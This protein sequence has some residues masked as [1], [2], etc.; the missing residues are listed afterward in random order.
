MRIKIS[1]KHLEHTEAIDKAIHEKTKKLDKYFHGVTQVIWTC[2]V[3]NGKHLAEVKILGPSFD[4]LARSK[5]DNLYKSLDLVLE[6]LEKQLEKKKDKWKNHIHH[7]SE[8]NLEF[9]DD[10]EAAFADLDEGKFDDVA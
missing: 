3:E 1:F 2:S 7:H 5:S 10:P 8:K 9:H 4:F 6:K